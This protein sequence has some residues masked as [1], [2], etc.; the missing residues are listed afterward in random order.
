[1]F[2]VKADVWSQ[3]FGARCLE[4][5]PPKPS[6][7]VVAPPLSPF[8]LVRVSRSEQMFQRLLELLELSGMEHASKIESV[9]VVTPNRGERHAS[10]PL[11]SG[12]NA[13]ISKRI[14][15]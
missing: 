4:A 8:L 13:R 2:T 5:S 12:Q 7:S 9:T 6:V 3:M 10:F 14:F 1:M 11:I 15:T